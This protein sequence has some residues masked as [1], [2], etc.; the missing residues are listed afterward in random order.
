MNRNYNLAFQRARGEYFKWASCSDLCA[1]T[2]LE[3]CVNELES[4]S[5]L[6]LCYGRTRLLRGDANDSESDPYDD[7]LDVSQDDPCDRMAH[8]LHDI[9]LNNVMNGVIR[10]GVLEGTSLVRD[11][12][13]SDIAL[14]AEL[15]LHGKFRQV[16]KDLF[17]RRMTAE[18]ATTLKSRETFLEYYDAGGRGERHFQRWQLHFSLLRAAWR[19]PLG[20]QQRVRVM[21]YL[22]RNAAWDRKRLL[23]EV[24]IGFRATMGSVRRITH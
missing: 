20:R 6:V 12:F 14:V 18:T 4:D 1:P 17:F 15:A 2:L 16:P 24:S 11:Y 13:S 3:D 5:E 23:R 10:R 22:L 19:A 7:G 9:K 8:V 21:R